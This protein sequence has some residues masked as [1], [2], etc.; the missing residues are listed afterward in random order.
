MLL[1]LMSGRFTTANPHLQTN[2]SQTAH[3]LLGKPVVLGEFGY[4][5]SQDSTYETWTSASFSSGVSSLKY[6]LARY[7]L[8][9]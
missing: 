4:K 6:L 1:G 2:H 9:K 8:T 7:A 3:N 5:N